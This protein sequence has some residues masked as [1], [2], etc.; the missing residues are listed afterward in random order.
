MCGGKERAHPSV[1]EKR[2]TC[3]MEGQAIRLHD[4]DSYLEYGENFVMLMQESA[5]RKPSMAYVA[6]I[7]AC[8]KVEDMAYLEALK[9]TSQPLSSNLWDNVSSIDEY[10]GICETIHANL[11]EFDRSDWAAKFAENPPMS[12]FRTLSGRSAAAFGMSLEPPPLPSIPKKRGR[13]P[14]GSEHLRVDTGRRPYKKRKKTVKE[15]M[16]IKK[17]QDGK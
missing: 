13:P 6:V 3:E 4:E 2:Y 16:K 9:A 5:R 12:L 10:Q 1:P 7:E 11:K 8:M 17:L 14:K 15:G